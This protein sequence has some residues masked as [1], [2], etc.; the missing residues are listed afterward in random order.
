MLFR[1][2]RTVIQPN[3]T[4]LPLGVQE[5][6]YRVTVRLPAQEVRAYGQAM[7]L[8]AGMVLDADVSIDRR[9]I[10]EWLFDPL[11]SVTGRV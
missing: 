2:G 11:L 8:R 6:V 1:S 7:A 3:E 5:P 4:S 10:V 9:R